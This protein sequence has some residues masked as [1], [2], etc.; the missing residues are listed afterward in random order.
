VNLV[1]SAAKAAGDAIK[2]RA[3]DKIAAARGF[4]DALRDSRPPQR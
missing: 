3:D 1:T 4:L 2:R